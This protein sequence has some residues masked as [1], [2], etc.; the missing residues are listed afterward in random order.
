MLWYQVPAAR[1]RLCRQL[2]SGEHFCRRAG[3]WQSRQSRQSAG[4]AE[5]TLH[6]LHSGIGTCLCELGPP[7]Q[8]CCLFLWCGGSPSSSFPRC[9]TRLQSSGL[10][11][12]CSCFCSWC[13]P[14]PYRS[15]ARLL[16]RTCERADAVCKSIAHVR[17]VKPD[18]CLAVFAEQSR[19]SM[20]YG[21]FDMEKPVPKR[22]AA[23]RFCSPAAGSSWS[24][25]PGVLVTPARSTPPCLLSPPRRPL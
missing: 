11:L 19:A 14:L 22:S 1:E 2:G 9:S 6:A 16:G 23:A 24:P 13:H 15:T 10:L 20:R 7:R 17:A 18:A 5:Y 4:E 3:R 12:S 21:G 8:R 25:A